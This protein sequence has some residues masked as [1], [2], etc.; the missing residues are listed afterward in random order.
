MKITDELIR[1]A[2]EALYERR[3]GEPVR[4]AAL[5]GP[6]W[7]SWE[8]ART[9]LEAASKYLDENEDELLNV[10]GRVLENRYGTLIGIGSTLRQAIAELK[11]GES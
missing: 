2:A 4:H 8:D 10:F 11:Q 7:D 1:A 5:L 9:A 3:H 6:G